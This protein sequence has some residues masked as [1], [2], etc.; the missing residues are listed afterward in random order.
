MKRIRQ[1]QSHILHSGLLLATTLPGISAQMT[2]LFNDRPQATAASAVLTADTTA[3]S[4]EYGETSRIH[5]STRNHTVW[6]EWIAPASG[7]V[8][9]DTLGTSFAKPMIAIYTG[10]EITGLTAVA[11]GFAPS[12]PNP[13]RVSFPVAA[14]TAYQIMLDSNDNNA[15]GDGPGVVNIKLTPAEIPPSVVGADA[16][17]ARPELSGTEA[18]GVANNQFAGLE[19]FEPETRFRCKNTIWWQWTAPATGK[20]TIDTLGSEMQSSLTVFAGSAATEPPFA[21][22]DP[23]AYSDD[24]P[25]SKLSRLSFQTEAGRTYQIVVDGDDAG[26]GGKGNIIL[27]LGLTPNSGLAAIPGADDFARRRQLSGF[28]AAGTASNVNFT[29][30]PFETS[31]LGKLGKTAWWQWTA[32]ADCVMSVDTIGST[33]CVPTVSEMDTELKVLAGTELD[34]LKEIAVNDDAVGSICSRLSF[35]AKKGVSYQI[36]VDRSHANSYSEGNIILNLNPVSAPEIAVQQ[37]AGS[38]LT[39]ALSKRSFG[40]VKTG[41]RSVTKTFTIRNAGNA[42][43]SGLAISRTGHHSADFI[44]GTL[45]KTSLVPGASTTFTVRFAPRAKGTRSAA[46]QIR[47]NDADENPFDIP[48][49]GLGVAR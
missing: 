9:I 15:G 29:T 38:E 13:A 40:T 27:H 3:A 48:L 49:V 19:A 39:D 31:K 10:S 20:V 8:V 7:W 25:N 24:I 46:I 4:L 17:S 33:R 1:I 16:F 42:T 12:S 34:V 2:D 45:A 6:A 41:L 43:L 30:E 26:A 18:L 37:P 22:L 32:P 14:G 47:S 35:S 28:N 5:G 11:R 21:D 23:V 44:V 36:V